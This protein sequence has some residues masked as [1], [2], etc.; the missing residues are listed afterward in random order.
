MPLQWGKVFAI[1]FCLFLA[2]CTTADDSLARVQQA[3]TLV[4]GV[5]PT[6]PPFENGDTGE[7][8]GLD[9]DL[10]RALGTQLGVTVTFQPFGYDGLYDALNTGQVDVL[11]S[12]L[13]VDETKTKD[14]VYTRPYFNAGQMLI[15]PNSTAI[16]KH[17]DLSNQI[18]A[19]ELG[20]EGHV[21]A[22]RWER[23]L[24]GLVIL[25]VATAGEALTAV[26][27]GTAQAALVDHVSGRL[28]L[29]QNDAPL[30]LLPTPVTVEPYALVVRQA[31]V[32]L[33]NALDNALHELE[34]SGALEGIISR[35]LDN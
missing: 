8:V 17:T 12:A 28:Y 1:L 16:A 27:T 32:T 21:Q 9:I 14:F 34:E 22:I 26:A 11:L 4:V 2:N 6:F 15:V 10:A 20:T 35:W 25:P 5:D 18:I 33:Y 23:E 7:L 3:G 19:V 31:D 30:Q 13:V 24:P 29:N